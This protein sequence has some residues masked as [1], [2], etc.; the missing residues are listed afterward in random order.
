MPIG[1]NFA[2]M[3]TIHPGATGRGSNTTWWA[4]LANLFWWCDVEKGVAGI[5]ATQILPF[6]GKSIHCLQGAKRRLYCYL[7]WQY[8]TEEP[9]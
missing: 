6:A 7:D 1:W 4:G 2:G 3:L 9:Y 8:M 5:I